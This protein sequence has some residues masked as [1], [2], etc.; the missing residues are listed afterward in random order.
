VNKNIVFKGLL[1][2]DNGIGVSSF[3]NTGPIKFEDTR[4]I[5]LTAKAR[6]LLADTNLDPYP[7]INGGMDKEINICRTCHHTIDGFKFPGDPAHVQ[8]SLH[9]VSFSGFE[10]YSDGINEYDILAW[11]L[12][13]A[14]PGLHGAGGKSIT[15]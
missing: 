4:V 3:D 2:A 7:V 13:D 10:P 5:G 15:R 1:L 8:L 6:E 9:S 11:R 14:F 12:W